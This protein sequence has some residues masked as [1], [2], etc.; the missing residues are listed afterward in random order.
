NAFEYRKTFVKGNT[1]R[2]VFSEGDLLPGL[3]IDKYENTL[4][5]QFLTLGMDTLSELVIQ[6]AE[7]V[8]S[9]VNIVLRNDSSSRTLE[10]LPLEKK[11]IKGN[12]DKLPVVNIGGLLFEVDPLAGQKTGFFLDQA[13]NRVA[14]AGLLKSGQT[15]L[16]LFCHTGA[17]GIEA[18]KRGAFVT[19]VDSSDAA[20]LRAKANAELNNANKNCAFVKADVFDFIKMEL[21]KGKSYDFIVLDPPAFVRSKANLKNGLRAYRD[22]NSAVMKLAKR[23]AFIATSS[24]SYHV[25]RNAFIEILRGAAKDAGKTCRITETRSQAKDHPVALFVPETEYLKCVIVQIS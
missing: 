23:G 15:G 5:M 18:A 6:A 24:C 25:D 10:G 2:A 17:W 9:P 8:F 1:F 7:A 12:L 21:A 19:G 3:I 22:I 13:E 20:V 16:D 14:F 11:I 4:S